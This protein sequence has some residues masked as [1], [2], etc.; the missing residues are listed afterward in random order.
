MTPNQHMHKLSELLNATTSF[1]LKTPRDRNQSVKLALT[2]PAFSEDCPLFF[3]PYG[4]CAKVT[5]STHFLYHAPSNTYLAIDC[6][7]VQGEDSAD[8]NGTE[9]LPVKPAE[10]KV[11]F[12]THA[13]VD[14]IGNLVA[15]L[16]AGFRGKIYCTKVT[17][18]LT[19]ICL[20]DSLARDHQ[21][22]ENQMLIDLLPPM[23]RCPDEAGDIGYEKSIPVEGVTGLN[24]SMHPTSH[25]IGCVA[26][27]L[28]V[29]N[30]NYRNISILFSADIGPVT[31][32]KIH[33]GLCP[34]RIIPRN[35]ADVIVLESTYGDRP[36][37]IKE[38]LTAEGR[39]S[40]LAD[41]IAK[42]VSKG[43]GSTL[44]IPAFSLG[45]TTDLLADIVV[46]LGSMRTKTNL[47]P[48]DTPKVY[49]TS[50]LAERYALILRDAYAT[51][52]ENCDY[53]WL[54]ED[55]K[56][57]AIGRLDLLRQLLSPDSCPRQLLTTNDGN[58]EVIWGKPEKGDELNIILA[59]SGTTAHGAIQRFI[60]EHA[61]DERTTVALAGYCPENSL[62]ARLREI[63]Q[64]SIER[65]SLERPLSIRLKNAEDG[66]PRFWE[67]A[68]ETIKMNLLDISSYYSGH[69]DTNSLIEYATTDNPAHIPTDI[70]LVHGTEQA[71]TQLAS[72]L[73][74]E[75]RPGTRKV[76]EVHCPSATYP[77]FDI[78]HR[79][80]NFP[81]LGELR[82]SMV[83][84]LPVNQEF[85]PS[86]RSL[87]KGIM[88]SL[89]YDY[90][91]IISYV[92]TPGKTAVVKLEGVSKNIRVNHNVTIRQIS[93]QDFDVSVDTTL[94][95]CQT[96]HE[97]MHRCFPWESVL[98][99][100]RHDLIGYK[101]VGTDEE[102]VQLLDKLGDTNRDY[103]I[104][105]LT[106][107]GSD[108]TNAKFISKH[109]APSN[110][111][112]YLMLLDG[113]TI[114][115]TK[116]LKVN[117][118]MGLYYPENPNLP[119]VEFSM[120]H[121]IQKLPTLLE[122]INTAEDTARARRK[123]VTI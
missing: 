13:H 108:N 102:I 52:C 17:A 21:L 37:R 24:F 38:N 72:R 106:K 49:I 60:M 110:T 28:T 113:R 51:L 77:W 7:L 61:D 88:K 122:Y 86:V 101:P 33:G 78:A 39:L 48:N 107:L 105:L 123:V 35:L 121:S 6:G 14:H 112:S 85:P 12:L 103:P 54:N 22:E 15:W 93:D 64:L 11:L 119:P 76:R 82:T 120:L 84:K 104:F 91:E 96:N 16:K 62:G 30:K 44:I 57:F 83:I 26:F 2:A 94:F 1:S 50:Q 89:Q 98:R 46:V 74:N 111:K 34:A 45:R 56:L 87:A 36:P 43:A 32:Q 41:V 29:F 19:K 67:I 70:I 71:R 18:E 31:D 68:A 65:R 40:A 69:A 10:I 115:W 66:K 109:L 5:G 25:L 4:A 75:L 81:D 3:K 58:I 114:A 79:R 95:E 118:G 97:F 116:G 53:R 23:F 100:L 20:E 90:P 9:Q 42:S 73:K 47:S 63:T 80:W 8:I 27:R 99:Y 117:N 55:S 92:R 59:G